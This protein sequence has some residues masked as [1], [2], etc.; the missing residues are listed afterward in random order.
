MKENVPIALMFRILDAIEEAG[1]DPAEALWSLE[2]AKAFLP[3]PRSFLKESAVTPLCDYV[4]PSQEVVPGPGD[5]LCSIP[6]PNSDGEQ[7]DHGG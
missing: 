2:G 3:G 4:N 1:V 6:G 5:V 7:P